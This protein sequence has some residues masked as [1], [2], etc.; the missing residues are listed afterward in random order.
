MTKRPYRSGGF[1]LIELLV[2][3][4]IIA[5]LAAMLLP[6][7][8]R[9]KGK[10]LA[11]QCMNNGKQVMLA[12]RMYVEDNRDKLPNV[13]P[14]NSDVVDADNNPWMFGWLDW[15]ADETN[16]NPDTDIKRSPLWPYCGKNP[17]IFKCPGDTSMVNVRGQMK[18]RVRSISSLIWVGGRGDSLPANWSEPN[19]VWRT[20]KMLS[21]MV[22]PGPAMTWV[23]IDEREDSINDPMFVVDMNGYPASKTTTINLVDIPAS[24]HSGSGSLSFADG[25]SETHRWRDAR[26]T[27]P[28]KKGVNI[29]FNE[30]PQPGNV[31]IMW[32]QERSTRKY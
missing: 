5:I 3:I 27:P 16:W 6:A 2:V 4:A 10:A 17:S 30:K 12:W 21:E 24:Y 15:D 26:T 31:D 11:I 29:D 23:F 19:G 1:T 22:Q 8:S 13:K 14:G 18:P 25:H 9:A 7:L 20:Y 28:I 32:L